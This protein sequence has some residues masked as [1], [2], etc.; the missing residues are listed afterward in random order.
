MQVPWIVACASPQE[1]ER[2]ELRVKQWGGGARRGMGSSSGRVP[3]LIV[4][5]LP[6]FQARR[7]TRLR[8]CLPSLLGHPSRQ[9]TASVRHQPVSARSCTAPWRSCSGRP[10]S[11]A[12]VSV[13]R[14][15]FVSRG[16]WA[17]AL[18]RWSDCSPLAPRPTCSRS[19][20]PP[21]RP[22]ASTRRCSARFISR[23]GVG[24]REAAP[25]LAETF[26]IARGRVRESCLKDAL[27][28]ARIGSGAP[29]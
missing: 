6:R 15:G 1:Q 18:D 28:I 7:L 8:R 17:R 16:R 2:G 5:G 4:P 9:R 29:R 25:G 14:F 10:S 11:C 12:S 22:T 3:A 26:E 23:V 24:V 21:S 19:T 27:A 20:I 13:V